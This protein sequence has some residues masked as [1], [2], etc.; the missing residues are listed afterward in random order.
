MVLVKWCIKW[1][2]SQN[3]C[4]PVGSNSKVGRVANLFRFKIFL[5]S[6]EK[7]TGREI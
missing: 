4:R 3:I 6:K 7:K 1:F 5:T 2:T